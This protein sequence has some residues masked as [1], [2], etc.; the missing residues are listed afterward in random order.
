MD[1]I[2]ELLEARPRSRHRGSPPLPLPASARPARGLRG[3]GRRLA[4]GRA[5]AV[6]RGSRRAGS[7]GGG[8]RP[9]RP[10]LGARGRRR[11]R[12]RPARGGRGRRAARA[13]ERRA[14]VR[15]RAAPAP[16]HRTG[17]GAHRAPRRTVGGADG[18]R[19]FRGQPR[20]LCSTPSR[21]CPTARMRYAP[22]LVRACAGV[23]SN[24]GLHEQARGRLAS[25][26]EALPDQDSPEAVALMIELAINRLWRAR[27]D[28]MHESAERAVT[29]CTTARG[30]ASDRGGPRRAR[31]W[32]TRRRGRRSEP[33]PTVW[34]R[35]HWS[36][37]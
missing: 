18:D 34:R 10:A 1:A 6:R 35:R 16:A 5:R 3:H 21:W 33:R 27:F 12:R 15:G 28:A 9:P 20:A 7:S 32:R 23:E 17:G 22:E 24:L 26:L 36:I 14:L 31:S 13:G 19:S 25:A 30:R 2:D 29:R 37:P 4:A 8:A 11:R